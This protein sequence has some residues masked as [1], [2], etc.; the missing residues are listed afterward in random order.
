MRRTVIGLTSL[1]LAC[2]LGMGMSGGA[3]GSATPGS[4]AAPTKVKAT[5]SRAAVH[6]LPSPLDTKRREARE[7][8]IQQVLAGDASV[9]TRNGS[10]V[11][12]LGTQSRAHPADKKSR[13][14]TP[15]WHSQSRYVEL[16]REKTDKVFVVLAE[17]GNERR[18]GYPDVDSDPDT[19]GPTTFDGPL[20]N[21]IPEPDR[22][23]D[24]STVWEPDFSSAYFQHMYFGTGRNVESLKTYYEQ[25]SSGRYSVQG[26]VSDWVKVP[27]N[28]ARYGRD[29]CG[30][31]VCSNVWAL[32]TDGLN[33]WVADQEA[34]GQSDAQIKATLASYDKWDRYDYD[35][36]GNFDEPDGYIDHFQIVHAGG[37][38]ADGDR[39]QGEDAIWS[40]RW[41]AYYNNIGATG[42]SYNEF[43]GQEIGDTG[44]W[45]GDY[46]M[47]AENGGL[48][49]IAHEYGHDLGLPD[50]Y[51][52]AGG[53]DNAVS[54]W[55]LMAQSRASA[56][57]D[58][59]IGTRPAD[60]GVWDKLVLGWL[61]YEVVPAGTHRTLKL[62]PHEYNSRDA[63]GVVVPLPPKEV[64]TELVPPAS[65]EN[66]WWSGSGNDLNNTLSRDVTLPAGVATLT[67]QANW[68]IEDC[69]P[70]PCD[71]AFVEVN[72]GSGWE[73]VAATDTHSDEGNAFDGTSEGWQAQTVDLSAYAGSTIGLRFRYATDGAV[74]GMG[75]FADD[76]VVTAGGAEVFA[77][78]AEDGDNGWIADG[79]TAVGAT[80]TSDYN[81]YYL[82]SYRANTSYDRYLRTGPYNFGW[83]DTRPDWVEHFPYQQG[84]LVNYWDTSFS[85]N[86]ESEHP[87]QGLVLPID[88]HP[89]PIYN[90]DGTVWRGRIQT[91]DA[92]FSLRKADS[93]TL[94]RNGVRSYIRGQAAQPV[95]NDMKSYWSEAQPTVGVK[96]ARAGVKIRVLSQ[97]STTMKVR[98]S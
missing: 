16:A 45:V 33:A 71:Y 66:S 44:I 55:T 53:P 31:V 50:H 68:D 42:P 70:D 96:V 7:T 29:V 41:Y 88:A 11:A 13:K 1:T 30:E 8:A 94:H 98:V 24:N 86:N 90:I 84:L 12:D 19:P 27:Y 64:T 37:D 77:D 76:I 69:G 34:K 5:P 83:A 6:D 79:F 59:G 14:R 61:D 62:G 89:R 3:W 28:E 54:W 72:D 57:G 92:P 73:S 46:T 63:Q 52:T 82:A 85:D 81:H 18:T 58:E 39:Y 10:T 60:L 80:S 74:G 67:F 2:G 97:S 95:F 75:F 47:Q 22:A 43:G 9:S 23:T 49:T 65:G 56:K 17:F 40:H 93:F 15:A 87:G 32:I 21:S 78:G 4:P 36:D 51:D 20:H 91:Y 35:G 25:Q 26:T 48:S 38:Q